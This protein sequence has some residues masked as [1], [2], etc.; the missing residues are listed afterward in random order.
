MINPQIFAEELTILEEW[1]GKQLTKAVRAR[2][3]SV[4]NE[5]L[6]DD[7]FKTACAL[8]FEQ[9]ASNAFNFP[10][11]QDFIS[12]AKGSLEELAAKDW[13]KV[14]RFD[15]QNPPALSKPGEIALK[16]LGGQN[17]IGKSTMSEVNWLRKDFEKAYRI[18]YFELQRKESLGLSGLPPAKPKYVFAPHG[19]EHL[20]GRG[21]TA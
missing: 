6:S 14:C 3:F 7:E 8:I 5:K 10:S 2:L 13:E 20:D 16:R 15:P 18:A 9:N 4:L 12:K 19:F 1:F 21:G 11:A 17:L